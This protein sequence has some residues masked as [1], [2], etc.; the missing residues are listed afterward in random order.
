MKNLTA[1][2]FTRWKDVKQQTTTLFTQ[3]NR[4]EA[5]NR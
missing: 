2:W 3:T 5:A 1:R 4:E